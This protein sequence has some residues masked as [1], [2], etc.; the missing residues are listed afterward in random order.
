MAGMTRFDWS[1]PFFLDAQ[2]T[3]EERMIRDAAKAYAEDKLQPRVIKAWSDETTDP[4]I[5][6]KWANW[7][8]SDRRCPRLTAGS[9]RLMSLMA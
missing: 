6:A 9:A 7:A 4:G 2:L 5:F 8:C 1:D 3:E